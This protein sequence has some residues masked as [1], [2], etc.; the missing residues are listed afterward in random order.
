MTRRDAVWRSLLVCL[1]SLMNSVLS[2]QDVAAQETVPLAD[3]SSACGGTPSSSDCTTA[4]N[5]GG[6]P[7]SWEW[8]SPANSM[9]QRCSYTLS[10]TPG[11]QGPWVPGGAQTQKVA[12]SCGSKST[13]TVKFTESVK[14]SA[15]ASVTVS[16]GVTV[17]ES[18]QAQINGGLVSA[19]QG[20]KVSTTF[21]AGQTTSSS[22]EVTQSD[23]ATLTAPGCGKVIGYKTMFKASRP[24]T[25]TLSLSFGGIC[26]GCN[27]TWQTVKTCSSNL[28][29]V[30]SDVAGKFTQC[31]LTCPGPFNETCTSSSTGTGTCNPNQYP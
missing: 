1:V 31:D 26:S 11:T 22:E 19:T 24:A 15:T 18:L 20:L 23:E 4:C 9:T 14:A 8:T 17:E 10:F 12:D 2:N 28:T 13:L 25:G 7:G 30:G 16:G 27:N 3:C 6:C 5:K 29:L 21:S